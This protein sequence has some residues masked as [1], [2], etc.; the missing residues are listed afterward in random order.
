VIPVTVLRRVFLAVAAAA[1]A[2]C[3]SSGARNR[4]VDDGI[5]EFTARTGGYGDLIGRL[6]LLD[7]E[8][9]L[10]PMQGQCRVDPSQASVELFY[11][12]CDYSTEIENLS[13]TIDRRLPLTRSLWRGFVRQTRTRSVCDQYAT[14]NGRQVCVRTRQESYEERARVG[15]PLTFRPQPVS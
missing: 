9:S 15:G 2:A 4:P 13:F 11:F 10:Q 12:L 3:A 6:T 7:G 14:Q 5:Y 8:V 1:S